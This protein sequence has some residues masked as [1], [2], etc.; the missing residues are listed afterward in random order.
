M[1]Q[2]YVSLTTGV[3]SLPS[4]VPAIRPPVRY[5]DVSSSGPWDLLGYPKWLCQAH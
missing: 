3:L 4:G 1:F 5:G 2:L